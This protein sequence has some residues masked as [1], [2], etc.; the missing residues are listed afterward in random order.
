MLLADTD[1]EAETRERRCRERL[2]STNS[3]RLADRHDSCGPG[4]VGN[5]RPTGNPL[6]C[7]ETT[8][9]YPET[10]GKN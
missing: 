10:T 6:F 7:Q 5:S 8:P 1:E 4:G 2:D 3:A 9:I